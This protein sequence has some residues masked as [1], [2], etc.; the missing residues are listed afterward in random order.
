MIGI[1]NMRLYAWL[2]LDVAKFKNKEIDK[3][4]LKFSL[5]FLIILN[6]WFT[7]PS[8]FSHYILSYQV[9]SFTKLV[10]SFQYDSNVHLLKF[11]SF[12]SF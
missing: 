7:F 11:H 12:A 6:D 4:I 8:N 2:F 5:G 10:E 1:L 3:K 9:R